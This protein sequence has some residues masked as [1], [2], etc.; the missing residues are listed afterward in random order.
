MAGIKPS[1]IRS[2][3]RII[4]VAA[5]IAS[6]L[7][8]SE[9]ASADEGDTFYDTTLNYL[10]TYNGSTWSPAGMTGIG[11]GSLDAAAQI[12][13]KITNA[14]AIEIEATNPASNLLILDSNGT[15]T[16]D[17][18]DISQAGGATHLINLTQAGTGKDI[19][20]TGSLWSV[21]KTGV[22]A[23]A[24]I[25]LADSKNLSLGDSGD[26]TIDYVDGGTP[27][28]AGAGLLVAHTVSDDNIQ[29]GNATYSFDVI[30]VGETATTN[31]MQWDLNGGADSVGALIFDNAD[32]DLGDSDLIR[33]GDSQAFTIG[34]V[35]SGD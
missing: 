21:E 16:A 29:F 3:A 18:L 9:K 5:T 30:F 26:V 17:V 27:G 32:I 34:Y 14:V 1:N 33:L 19:D 23:F 20:G 8:K 7:T 24:G 12:G 6:F 28:T 2:D 13:A 11:P 31:F 35:N 22:G 25:G 4:V 10:R 15:G